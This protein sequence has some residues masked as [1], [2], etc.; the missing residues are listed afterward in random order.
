MSNKQAKR[1]QQKFIT[2][3]NLHRKQKKKQNYANIDV[4]KKHELIFFFRHFSLSSLFYEYVHVVLVL[5]GK[6]CNA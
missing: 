5:F 1:Q 3:T 2:T 6:N 4:Q